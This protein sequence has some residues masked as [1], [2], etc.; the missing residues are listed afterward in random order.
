[1]LAW[2]TKQNTNELHPQLHVTSVVLDSVQAAG[3]GMDMD[4][5]MNINHHG[6]LGFK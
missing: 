6:I 5:V 4:T 3:R 2:D 1:M